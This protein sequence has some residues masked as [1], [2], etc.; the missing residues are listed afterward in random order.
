M[1]MSIWTTGNEKEYIDGLVSGK[2]LHNCP[3]TCAI[4]VDELLSNYI[5]SA[6]RRKICGTF[7]SVNATEVIAYADKLKGVYTE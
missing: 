5:S 1:S 4:S 3:H 6:T 7:G 2:N